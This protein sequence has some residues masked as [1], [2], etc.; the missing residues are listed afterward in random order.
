MGEKMVFNDRRFGFITPKD[1][2]E[3]V[4]IHW[5]QLVGTKVLKQ[6]DTVSYDTER[7]GKYKAVNCIVT[8][9]V[10]DGKHDFVGMT[11]YSSGANSWSTPRGCDWETQYRMTRQMTVMEIT[12]HNGPLRQT[13]VGGWRWPHVVSGVY[14]AYSRRGKSGVIN[15]MW[16]PIEDLCNAPQ[17][18]DVHVVV[19]KCVFELAQ[20]FNDTEEDEA[21]TSEEWLE[22]VRD[23]VHWNHRLD[24]PNRDAASHALGC[25][26]KSRAVGEHAMDNGVGSVRLR[27]AEAMAG[28]GRRC[29][30]LHRVEVMAMLGEVV[31]YSPRDRHHAA[32]PAASTT[33]GQTRLA[34]TSDWNLFPHFVKV[35][36]SCSMLR[37]QQFASSCQGARPHFESGWA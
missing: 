33:K 16:S 23:T 10:G 5:K 20:A 6:E 11:T 21:L 9:S 4:C 30:S 31:L 36:V 22:L 37:S 18:L 35:A 8:P 13:V 17:C 12:T 24:F 3:D 27:Q 25:D 34:R 32:R 14:G 28:R 2:G 1:G 26:F 7:K 19:R 29:L 15:E